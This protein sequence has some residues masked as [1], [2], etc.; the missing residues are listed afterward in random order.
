[1]LYYFYNH[2]LIVLQTRPGSYVSTFVNMYVLLIYVRA[3]FCAVRKATLYSVMIDDFRYAVCLGKFH[4]GHLNVVYAAGARL[5]DCT[6]KLRDTS[7][8]VGS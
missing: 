5:E 8:S 7:F 4:F 6:G 1:M 3:Y 2:I